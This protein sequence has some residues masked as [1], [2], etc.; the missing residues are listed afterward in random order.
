[1]PVIRHTSEANSRLILDA[2][3]DRWDEAIPLGNGLTGTLLWGEGALVRLSLDRGDLWDV[4]EPDIFH[5][6][7]W[8]YTTLQ[9]CVARQDQQRIINDFE[10]AKGKYPY[11][12]KIPAGRIELA[13]TAGETAK[14]FAIDLRRAVGRITLGR[15]AIDVYL[16]ATRP[17]G[18]V[19][20]HAVGVTPRLVAPA[21]GEPAEKGSWKLGELGYPPPRVGA[22]DERQWFIQK[23]LGDLLYVTML[24]HRGN[25]L[26]YTI[27]TNQDTEDPLAE[28][29]RRLDEVLDADEGVILGDHEAW[30]ADFWS[31][32]DIRLPHPRLEH[33]Y[34][35]VQYLYGAGSRLGAPPLALQGVWTADE[36]SL[37]PWRG[38]FHHDL[39]SQ[40]IYWPY[41]AAGHVDEGLSYLQFLW[42]CLPAFR[43]Y[44]HRFYEVPGAVVPCATDIHGRPVPGWA[45]YNYQL[46]NGA[47]VAHGF[48][49]HWRYTMDE[50]F[51][52]DRAYPFCAEIAAAIEALLRPDPQ[53]GK[54]KLPLSASPEVHG[55]ELAAWMKPNSSY[56][57][58]LMRWLFAALDE[59]AHQ[60]DRPEEAERWRAVLDQL[61]PLPISHTGDFLGEGP[62]PLLLTDNTP[63][64][65]SHRHHSHLMAVHPLGLLHVEGSDFDRKVID[66]SLR[67]IARLGTGWWCGYSFSWMACIAARC[68]RPGMALHMLD[69][70]LKGF[71]SRNGFHL[72]G[73][74]KR[75]GMSWC[76]YRPF[77]LE[78]N[79]A[80]A[81]AVHE[82]LLQSWGGVVRVFPAVPDSW[83]DVSFDTLRAEGALQVSAERS[84]GRTV[85]VRIVSRHGGPLRLRDPFG[86]GRVRWIGPE[87]SRDDR[88]WVCRLEP[89]GTLEGRARGSG[90]ESVRSRAPM[91]VE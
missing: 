11:P 26:A 36:G 31:R 91:T 83:A 28:A 86:G 60:L 56:D 64:H 85:A 59:M 18:I 14:T 19:R 4:R 54:L 9:H 29:R 71:I 50:G 73:D 48:Y 34:R 53:T 89:G 51:L 87:P 90:T 6:P 75:L 42:D 23:T 66:E 5:A 20:L 46:G 7:D 45:Q 65:E 16:A 79:F 12:T 78:G 1:M 80:A 62:G 76:D 57:L 69:C 40:L 63:L 52:A 67:Q 49:L 38:D 27:V 10:G 74:F 44:A 39:N 81:Q 58:A 25:L 2:P 43:D 30:W 41:L 77:T 55:H 84:G 70:Y 21:F 88:D 15:G 35:F 32:S 8:K 33:H 82:M 22:D 61:D 3:I 17:V 47:W 72:N 13:L 37:P 24:R 68:G